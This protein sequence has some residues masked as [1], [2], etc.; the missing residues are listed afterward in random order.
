MWTVDSRCS[1]CGKKETCADR[2]VIVPDLVTMSNTL[3][4]SEEHLTTPGDGILI[5]V[6]NDFTP[7]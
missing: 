5:M 6:C 3:N 7:Q 1:Q 4:T 2:K